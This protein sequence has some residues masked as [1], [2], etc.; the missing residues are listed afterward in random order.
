MLNFHL[1]FSEINIQTSRDIL[2]QIL[3][4]IEQTPQL[5]RVSRHPSNTGGF[6]GQVFIFCPDCHT[7]INLVVMIVFQKSIFKLVEIY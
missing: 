6:T 7:L 4:T 2:T 5:Q 3:E 1:C